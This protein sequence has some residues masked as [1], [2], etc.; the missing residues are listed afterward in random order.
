MPDRLEPG[1]SRSASTVSVCLVF[2]NV[3]LLLV[4]T[5][6]RDAGTSFREKFRNFGFITYR[7]FSLPGL[8]CLAKETDED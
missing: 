6:G 5:A 3:D 8:S 1:E 4:I 7:M 2:L